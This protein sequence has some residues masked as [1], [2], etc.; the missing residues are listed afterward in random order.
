MIRNTQQKVG[1]DFDD[2]FESIFGKSTCKR[3]SYVQIDGKLVDKADIVPDEKSA[4]VLKPFEPFKSPIDG[5]MITSRSK[6]AKHNKQHGV[7]DFRDYSNGFI[8]KRAAERIAEGQRHLRE[9]RRTDMID[10]IDRHS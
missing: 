7:T 1:K 4:M 6:L 2:N 9:T 5:K 3:G 10:A 8:E